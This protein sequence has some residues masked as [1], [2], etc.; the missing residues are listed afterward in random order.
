VKICCKIKIINDIKLQAV[1]KPWSS[2]VPTSID[3]FLLPFIVTVVTDTLVSFFDSVFVVP[4][5]VT[6]VNTFIEL[7]FFKVIKSVFEDFVVVVVKDVLDVTD[8]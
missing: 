7:V 1:H 5:V 2:G 4:Y 6:L 8:E 3:L